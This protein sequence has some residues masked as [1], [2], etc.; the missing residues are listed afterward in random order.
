MGLVLRRER[1]VHVQNQV[2]VRLRVAM[3]RGIVPGCNQTLTA[4]FAA[5]L[6]FVPLV[7]VYRFVHRNGRL[8]VLFCFS[9]SLCCLVVCLFVPL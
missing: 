3:G 9:R 2:T 6:G 5:A 4:S 1:A 7:L 8:F